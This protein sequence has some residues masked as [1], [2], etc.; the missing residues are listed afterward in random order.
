MQ[1]LQPPFSNIQLE[2]LQ[3][4]QSN[5]DDNDLL[6]IKKLI[7]DYFAN[8]AIRMA[9]KIWEEQGWDDK[10]KINELLKTKMRTPYNKRSM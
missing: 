6:A 4:Y 1:T 10:K 9:D 5:V 3:L 2:L 7:A 8:N